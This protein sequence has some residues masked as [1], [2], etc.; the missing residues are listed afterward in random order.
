MARDA[1]VGYLR[2]RTTIAMEKEK[3]KNS[4][5]DVNLSEVKSD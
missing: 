1:I 3:D 5:A 4:I 2:K